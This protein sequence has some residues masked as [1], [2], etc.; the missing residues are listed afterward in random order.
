MPII[1]YETISSVCREVYLWQHSRRVG[2]NLTVC[3]RSCVQDVIDFTLFE[4]EYLNNSTH[5]G[6]LRFLKE[7]V[8]HKFSNVLFVYFV[9]VLSPT[10]VLP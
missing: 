8:P 6:F 4:I 5:K 7:K 1:V 2:L 9:C 3:R 10:D